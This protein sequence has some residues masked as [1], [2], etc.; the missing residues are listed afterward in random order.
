M[1]VAGL[2]TYNHIA[3]TKTSATATQDPA[4]SASSDSAPATDTARVYH[5][6][7]TVSVKIP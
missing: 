5:A 4:A 7:G 2:T 3:G 1:F 6:S